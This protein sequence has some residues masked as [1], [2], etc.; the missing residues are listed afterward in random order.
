MNSAIAS[1]PTPSREALPDRLRGISLL[2]IVVVNAAF[3]GAALAR[4]E[5]E[6]TWRHLLTRLPDRQAW[7]L[8]GTP[9]PNPGRMI[10]ELRSLPVQVSGRAPA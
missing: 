8:A 9:V 5:A 2:G 1:S 3:L 10:H 6:V 7:T 4:M